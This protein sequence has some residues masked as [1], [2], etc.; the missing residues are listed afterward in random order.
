M[1]DVDETRGLDA[2]DDNGTAASAASIDG[3]GGEQFEAIRRALVQRRR[4]LGLTM[5]ELARQVGV[6]PS[7]VSQIERGQSLPSVAT[8]FALA[9]ALG[10]T[11]DAFFADPPHVEAD[12]SAASVVD[13]HENLLS[14]PGTEAAEAPNHLYVVR[15][16]GRSSIDI[17]GG[18]HWERLTPVSLDQI[19]FLEII[20]EPRA[21]SDSDLYRHPGVEM[22][23]V[24]EGAFTI[25]IGFDS[26]D[27][28]P[29][30]S[31]AFPSSLPHC[32]VNSTDSV[33]RAVTV[34][35]REPLGSPSSPLAVDAIARALRGDGFDK[36][37]P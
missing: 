2:A 25:Q 22:V 15:S 28:A 6:S 13:A 30:D 35:L 4:E 1:S 12:R 32:Y 29:G 16:G 7:M 26:Y 3:L 9:A 10:A 33:S 27:L 36:E 18:V 37:A 34:I 20:Y 23:L 5:S 8:L 14:A 19:E 17:R 21:Q 11:V 24:L 31:I